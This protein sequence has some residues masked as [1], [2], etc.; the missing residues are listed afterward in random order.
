MFLL[1]RENLDLEKEKEETEDLLKS[2]QKTI[3]GCCSTTEHIHENNAIKF[4]SI[5]VG[6]FHSKYDEKTT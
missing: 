2:L 3:F 5:I 4:F 1:C 6:G